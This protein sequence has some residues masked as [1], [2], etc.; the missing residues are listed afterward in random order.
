M[1]LALRIIGSQG[2]SC[3]HAKAGSR[4]ARFARDGFHD[5][6]S[7]HHLPEQTSLCELEA[8]RPGPLWDGQPLFRHCAFK[9]DQRSND[10]EQKPVAAWNA[11]QTRP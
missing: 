10:L 9:L 1:H 5:D 6:S 11:R 7:E 2:R 4:C 8:R 3:E